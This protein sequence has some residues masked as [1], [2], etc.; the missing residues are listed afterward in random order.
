MTYLPAADNFKLLFRMNEK[1]LFY[2]VASKWN[3]PPPPQGRN[4]RAADLQCFQFLKVNL[5]VEKLRT[6]KGLFG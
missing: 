5:T 3:N 6:M 4:P 2:L 1:H